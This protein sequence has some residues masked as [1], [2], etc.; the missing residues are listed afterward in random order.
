MYEIII[1]IFKFNDKSIIILIIRFYVRGYIE[2]RENKN[3][4]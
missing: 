1:I 4:R 3:I 2:I